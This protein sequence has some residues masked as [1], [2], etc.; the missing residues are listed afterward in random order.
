MTTQ[1]P[2]VSNT[3]PRDGSPRS[4]DV[5]EQFTALRDTLRGSADEVPAATERYVFGEVFARGGLGQ[6]RHA[7]DRVLQRTIAVKEMLVP[8]VPTGG[9]RQPSTTPRRPRFTTDFAVNAEAPAK[10]RSNA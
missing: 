7:F 3:A 6:I 5:A 9:E 10:I 4:A 8:T 1:D 2:P